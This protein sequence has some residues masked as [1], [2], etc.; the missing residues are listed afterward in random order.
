[1]RPL[2]L[3]CELVPTKL[4]NWARPSPPWLLS[5][6][7]NQSPRKVFDVFRGASGLPFVDRQELCDS[8]NHSVP[9]PEI[10]S[11]PFPPSLFLR[12]FCPLHVVLDNSLL[13][14]EVGD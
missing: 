3:P 9:K 2:P 7:A 11:S 14:I 13:P 6:M 10:A 5:A 8:Q 4:G 12:S 1:M